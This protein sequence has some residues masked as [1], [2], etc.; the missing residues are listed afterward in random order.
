MSN[1]A[2]RRMIERRSAYTGYIPP[3][4]PV[5]QE[6][7][8]EREHPPQEQ[9]LEKKY[10]TDFS[11]DQKIQK[12]KFLWENLKELLSHSIYEKQEILDQ[13]KNLSEKIDKILD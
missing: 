9:L 1:R 3:Q 6:E 7:L 5:I 10:F 12:I 13:V 4:V 8:V 11:D 2:F